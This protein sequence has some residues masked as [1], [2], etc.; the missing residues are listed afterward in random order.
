MKLNSAFAIFFVA[1]VAACGKQAE[2]RMVVLPQA[3]AQTQTD[4]APMRH[5]FARTE[6]EIPANPADELVVDYTYR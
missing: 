5:S 2:S 1:T 3:Q 4:E 6:F